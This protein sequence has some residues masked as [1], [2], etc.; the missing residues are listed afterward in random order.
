MF[1]GMRGGGTNTHWTELLEDTE[2]EKGFRAAFEYTRNSI[3]FI[4]IERHPKVSVNDWIPTVCITRK[5]NKK[6]RA[7]DA[8]L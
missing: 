4:P 2:M 5:K 6:C 3:P 8:H 1:Q 7:T